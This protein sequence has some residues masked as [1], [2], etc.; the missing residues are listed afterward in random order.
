MRTVVAHAAVCY[1]WFQRGRRFVKASRFVKLT[2]PHAVVGTPGMARRDGF[3]CMLPVVPAGV[4]EQFRMGARFG[5]SCGCSC[6]RR[7]FVWDGP[8]QCFGRA[9][10][11]VTAA[12]VH[13]AGPS[14]LWLDRRT[15]SQVRAFCGR[16]SRM[17]RLW[18]LWPS[19]VSPSRDLSRTTFLRLS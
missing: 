8:T 13:A 3:D 9:P 6:R 12:V 5:N 16:A 19:S 18:P 14:L 2:L 11:L 4:D 10:I 1:Y 17:F 15:V 7:P